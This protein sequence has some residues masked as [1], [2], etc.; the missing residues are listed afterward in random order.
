MTTLFV[1]IV[2]P[3]VALW[4]G[5]ATA[6]IARSSEGNFTILPQHTATVGDIVPGI[7]R[8]ETNEGEL[9]FLV[10]GGYFQVDHGDV[11][12]Q[13]RATVLAGVAERTTDIDLNRAQIAKDAAEAE[14]AGATKG[15][16]VEASTLAYAQAALARAELRLNT[17]AK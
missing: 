13:T 7:V 5:D 8:V 11:D 3:E 12:G 1:E 9:S 16:N 14:I 2:T 15:E 4:S 6:L 17:A 10:H